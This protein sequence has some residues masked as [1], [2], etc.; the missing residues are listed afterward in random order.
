MRYKRWSALLVDALDTLGRALLQPL[1]EL[2]LKARI[3]PQSTVLISPPGDL[4]AIPVLSARL[5]DKTVL[6]DH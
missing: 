3:A 2:L 5:D 4:A 6:S 1:L